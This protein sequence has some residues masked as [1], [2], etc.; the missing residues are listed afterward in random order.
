MNITEYDIRKAIGHL[1]VPKSNT[2]LST[3]EDTIEIAYLDEK[4][5]MT[6]DFPRTRDKTFTAFQKE[7]LT[8]IKI[9]LGI[10]KVILNFTE[11]AAVEINAKNTVTLP[12]ARYIA[13]VSGKGGV[14]KSTITV[15]LA[16]ALMKKGKKIAIID[17]DIYGSSIPK[18]L[19]IPK[20]SPEIIG[21][22]VN[23]FI[24]DGIQV[25]SSS[26]LISENKPVMWK[27]PMLSKLLRQFF[28][29]VAWH[30]DTDFF[31]IDMPPG[32]GDIMLEVQ[33]IIQRCEMLVITTPQLD[34]AYVATKAGVAALE[35]GHDIIGVIENMSYVPC[36]N[37][38]E[39][40]YVFGRGGGYYVAEA[41]GSDLLAEIPLTQELTT[42]YYDDL[43]TIL[44]Q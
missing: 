16:K 23:P 8:I 29:D 42:G 22:Q 33:S 4:L 9:K 6:F 21:I 12:D 41:L 35:L 17:A 20:K 43:V 31:L 36:T 13:I 24:I 14:G 40:N 10:D 30:Q 32:T 19:Q 26:L 5:T 11:L 34:A 2:L 39:K 15:N 27:G 1:N 18:I 25:I 37:C 7:L 38:S 28:T 3:I 44:A